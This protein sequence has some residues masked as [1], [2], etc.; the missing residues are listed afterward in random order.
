MS[1]SLQEQLQRLAVPQTT[2]LVDLRRK[3]SILFDFKEA[4]TK[5]RR[6]IYDL[7]YAGLQELIAINPVF[8][9]F[10]KTLFDETAI[11]IERSVESNEI[12]NL[13][14]KNI[15]K[16]LRLLSPYFLLRP[17]HLC[18]E[19]LIRRF[20]INEYNKEV[21]LALCFPFH[22]TNIFIKIL[23][24]IRLRK[25]DDEWDW[26]KPLQK[27]GCRV[28][29][30]AIINRAL[31]SN[32]FYTFIC[33]NTLETVQE[34]GLK[35]NLLRTQINFYMAVVLGVFAQVQNIQEWHISSLL[36]SLMDG[37]SSIIIDYKSAAYMITAQ[38]AYKT[39][40]KPRF[41]KALIKHVVEMNIEPLRKSS[42]L[43]LNVIFDVQKTAEATLSP[44]QIQY[45]ADQEWFI[46]SVVDI[47]QSKSIA[48]LMKMFVNNALK[49][50]QND[51]ENA[52][53][54]IKFMDLFLFKTHLTYI[55]ALGFIK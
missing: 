51:M 31:S 35:A 11:N 10:E 45:L 42:I 18:L 3:V 28:P 1:T 20:Q 27:A 29:K 53:S 2:A 38:I 30:S 14:D 47:S 40:I 6:T 39:Q 33:N 9:D 52:K 12:N 22:D 36:P 37:L 50:M 44:K 17:T 34:W 54:I 48:P 55:D 32:S 19:W 26:L 15:A 24:T 16:F 5:D 43:V 49:L 13:L 25:M 46:N 23:Q 7:G 4:A 8:K 41:C 21:L